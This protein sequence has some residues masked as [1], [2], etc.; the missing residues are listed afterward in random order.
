MMK[1]TAPVPNGELSPILKAKGWQESD[2]MDIRE[3]LLEEVRRQNLQEISGELIV[4]R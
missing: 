4:D 3:M 1:L 2:I